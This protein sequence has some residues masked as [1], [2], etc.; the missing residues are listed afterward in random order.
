MEKYFTL[1]S[2][3]K[4]FTLESLKK[5]PESKKQLEGKN[6][7]IWCG[8]HAAW[9]R[10]FAAGYTTNKSNVGVYVFEDAWKRTYHCGPE[11][12]IQYQIVEDKES[13]SSERLLIGKCKVCGTIIAG[14]CSKDNDHFKKLAE[15]WLSRGLTVEWST[16]DH[17]CVGMCEHVRNKHPETEKR[18]KELGL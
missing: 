4:C 17:C 6:V 11:K 8:E 2:L 18:I 5:D 16:E 3:G 10:P 7:L 14:S 12:D 13:N 1:E 9:F 15:D